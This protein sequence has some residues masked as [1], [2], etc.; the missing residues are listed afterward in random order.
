VSLTPTLSGTPQYSSVS[1]CSIRQQD[2]RA[3]AGKLIVGWQEGSFATAPIS[4]S[5]VVRTDSKNNE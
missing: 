2:Q 3:I 5:P 4:S 1:D